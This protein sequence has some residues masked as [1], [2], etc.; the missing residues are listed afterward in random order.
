ML[1]T[2][3]T[4]LTIR[5]ST[6]ANLF[7][8]YIQ[9]LPLIRKFVTDNF[10]ANLKIKRIFTV[11]ALLLSILW[12]F[13]S[14][15]LYIGLL[16]YLPV[17]T[18]G[19]MLSIEDQF[20]L[21]IHIFVLISFLVAAVSNAKILEPKREKYVAVKLMRLS[22]TRYM[23][24]S[25]SHR[26]ILF[27]LYL[28]PAMFFF[29]GKL[30]A[31]PVQAV[32]IT[33]V[34][35]MWRVL[36]EYLHLKLFEKTG[37]ILV[38]KIAAVWIVI[39]LGYAAAYLPLLLAMIPITGELLLSW[40][41]LILITGLGIYATVRL[42][43]YS[44]YSTV[45]DAATKRDDPLLDINRMMIE[46]QKSSVASKDSDY[47]L[48]RT[49][50]NKFNSKEGYAYLNAIFFAR[51]RSNII[52]PVYKRIAI[53][54]GVGAVGVAIMLIFDPYAAILRSNVGVIFPFLM[55]TMS[56]LSVGE[57]ICKAMFYNCDV[58]LLRYGFYR[59]AAFQHFLL[60]LIRITSL[61]LWIAAALGAA[62]TII[63][64]ASGGEVWSWEIIM[65][66]IG[67]LLISVLFSVHHLFVYYIF[68][69]YSTE[70]NI[71]DPLYFIVTMLVSFV[72]GVSIVVRIPIDIFTAIVSAL[73][74]IYLFIAIVVVRKNGSRTFR[75]K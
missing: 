26:Y 69:P 9:K 3:N 59:K 54:G 72:C 31:S 58:S 18:F 66:W 55:L 20:Q 32:L 53:I 15:L 30:G 68:Q 56:F 4:L 1:R 75:V 2:L 57:R 7:I 10:Y 60:R 63:I 34:V 71:K 46:A 17:V 27:A 13:V 50:S 67:I 70:R 11:I 6:I 24:A 47:S 42:A 28:M 33:I 44:D 64:A 35:T 38:K 36:S 39:G 23:Q 52:E 14:R 16:I 45:V 5:I 73:T 74:L 12:G 65:L 61:N 8:F 48:E 19:E 22:P 51:H 21:F 25:L 40:P 49:G 62:L 41:V 43:T 29:G 37:A